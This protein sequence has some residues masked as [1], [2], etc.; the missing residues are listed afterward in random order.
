MCPVKILLFAI[1]MTV[2]AVKTLAR[3]ANSGG[4]CRT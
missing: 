4:K 1:I 2:F 3:V